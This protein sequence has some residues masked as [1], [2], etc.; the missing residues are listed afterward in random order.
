MRNLHFKFQVVWSGLLAALNGAA[1]IYQYRQPPTLLHVSLAFLCCLAVIMMANNAFGY[2]YL[3]YRVQKDLGFKDL[4]EFR[5]S[6]QFQAAMAQ[7][8]KNK[9]KR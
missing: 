3:Q 2:M 1:A 9:D 7:K 4:Q 5:E 6:P 8:R